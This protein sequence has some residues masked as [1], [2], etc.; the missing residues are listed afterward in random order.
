MGSA[1]NDRPPLFEDGAAPRI[2]IT[3]FDRIE[4]IDSGLYRYVATVGA[5]QSG[6]RGNMVVCYID[7]TYAGVASGVS[8]SL[9]KIK[10][11]ASGLWAPALSI[12]ERHH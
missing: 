1:V 10:R 5:T 4:D 2:L 8:Q 6:I 7:I 12:E 11:L 3:G 9:L